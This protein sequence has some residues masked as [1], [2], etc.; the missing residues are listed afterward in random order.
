MSAIRCIKPCA[1]TRFHLFQ[2]RKAAAFAKSEYIMRQHTIK[3]NKRTGSLRQILKSIGESLLG[4]EQDFTT[5]PLK[6]AI[7]LLAVPMVLEMVME[8]V[9]AV[10]DI[11]FVS[12]LGSDAVAAVGIT[13]SLMTLLYALAF[14]LAMGTTALVSRRIGEH[15]TREASREGMQALLT[16]SVVALCIAFPGAYFARDLLQLMGAS[17]EAVQ[18]HAAYTSIMFG[19]NIVI[20]LLFVLNAIFRGAGDAAIAMRVLWLANG[21]NILLDP[22][23]IFGYGP[24]PEMGVAGAAVATNIGRG[25]AVA[26]QLY[27]LFTG[28]SR[29]DLR[30]IPFR[31]DW[32]RIRHL[33]SISMGGIG[34]TLISTS[35]WVIL[36]RI[37]AGFGS[38]VVAAYTIAIRIIVFT[39]L[40]AWGLSNAASTL[41][42]QNLGAQEPERAEKAVWRVARVNVIF[43]GLLGVLFITMPRFFM[44]LL[45][46]DA[47]MI[48][49]GRVALQVMAFGFVFYSLGMVM[50]QSF[51]GAGDTRTPTRINL[52]AFWV[53]ET[54]IA[55]MLAHHTPM[56]EQ[57]VYYAIV[58]SETCMTLMA[59]YLFRKGKWKLEKV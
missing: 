26:Y 40:P 43:M 7:F 27:I 22:L 39:L 16:A 58:I 21:L 19:G 33:L 50:I 46:P 1:N 3:T 42:G 29:I 44:G 2:I 34:Q 49:L 59:W 54:P 47:E 11:Y 55:Y 28:R 14:G 52:I 23:L 30:S 13:E 12:R 36:I 41:V 48:E 45:T 9:F 24:F 18:E 37:L 35:S 4:T 38:E 31:P 20:M 32:Q 25:V 57:G 15:H 56:L 8:S 10:V 5:I 53:L 17:A 51:N 6:R